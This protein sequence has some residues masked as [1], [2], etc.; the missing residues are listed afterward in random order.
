MKAIYIY[1]Y[2]IMKNSTKIVA[3]ILATAIITTWIIS[4]YAVW[5]WQGQWQ[6]QWK[7]IE[8]SLHGNGQWQHKGQWQWNWQWSGKNSQMKHVWNPWDMIKDIAPSEL[9]EQEKLDL[10]YQ[11]SEE[12]VAYDAYNYFYSLYEVQNFKNIAESEA[13]HMAAVKVLLDRYSLATPTTYGELQSTFDTLKVEWEK[14]LQSALEV[15]LKIEMLDINDI[16]DTIKTTD[17]DDLKIVFTNIW[18]A[19]YNH[20][21]WF[22]QWLSNAWLSTSIDYSSYLTTA[23]LDKKWTLKTKLAEKLANEWVI[24]PVQASAK[25]IQANCD[26]EEKNM[27]EVE[28]NKYQI[29]KKYG[30]LL[31]KLQN[32]KLQTLDKKVDAG[33]EKIKNSS[34]MSE[35]KKEQNL[36]VYYAMKE[37]IAWL[38]R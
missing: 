1:N 17:N 37:Y 31:K 20:M 19:S 35:V 13:E 36:N 22:L 5:N 6:G 8:N 29:D 34:Q 26:K 11:Y 24:V 28:K 15:G 16:V 10:A 2:K 9:S 33:I 32:E 21:R 12:K 27:Q 3:S 18:W 23:D 30:N 38:F 25:N 7:K 4:T 14:S